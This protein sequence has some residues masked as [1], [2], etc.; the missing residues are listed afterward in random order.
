M[1]GLPLA[2]PKDMQEDKEGSSTRSPALS[3][4]L[5]AMTGMVRDMEP[6]VAAHEEGGRRRAMPPR[7]T[8]PTGWCATLGLPFREAHHV[9]GRIVVGGGRAQAL[10]CDRL[11]LEAMQAIEPRIT[12]DVFA[13]LS[14]DA[15]GREPHELRRHGARE[16]PRRRPRRWLEI[17]RAEKRQP[18]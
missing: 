6:D 15:F 11:P 7:P 8:S 13:V 16:R 3:L 10:R 4:S 17:A 18:N 14:V 2:Y 1:K 12:E 5:A 9:T